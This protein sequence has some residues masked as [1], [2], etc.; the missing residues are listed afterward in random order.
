MFVLVLCP[1]LTMDNQQ[2]FLQLKTPEIIPLNSKRYGQDRNSLTTKANQDR[3][4]INISLFL[5]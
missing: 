5:G 3:N 1:K 2:I 4:P